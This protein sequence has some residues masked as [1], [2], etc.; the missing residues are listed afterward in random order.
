MTMVVVLRQSQLRID[1]T[2]RDSNLWWVPRRVVAT[3]HS[4]YS[5]HITNIETGNIVCVGIWLNRQELG[6]SRSLPDT[7]DAEMAPSRL[8]Y[9]RQRVSG[10]E[11]H[12]VEHQTSCSSKEHCIRPTVRNKLRRVPSLVI[13]LSSC[14]VVWITFWFAV[15]IMCIFGTTWYIKRGRLMC[16]MRIRR[17]SSTNR[18]MR[19][20]ALA[21]Q[22]VASWFW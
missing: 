4:T 3:A 10:V 11:S 2:G 12:C 17:W 6:P 1:P 9:L 13:F 20:S 5:I 18:T 15:A 21:S 19:W 7:V 14:D 16:R 22:V 8:Q